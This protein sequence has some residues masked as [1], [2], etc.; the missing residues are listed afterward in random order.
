MYSI[1]DTGNIGSAEKGCSCEQIRD[2]EL[3][4]FGE[5]DEDA[6]KSDFGC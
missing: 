4:E 6:F 5:V 2:F 1:S 3:R